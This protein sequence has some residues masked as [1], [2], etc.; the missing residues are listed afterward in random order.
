MPTS[1][2][3][4]VSSKS[5]ENCLFTSTATGIQPQLSMSHTYSYRTRRG[6]FRIVRQDNE[7]ELMFHNEELGTYDEPEDAAQELAAG[8][9][10]WP[11]FGDPS[12]LG[13]PDDLSFWDEE[14]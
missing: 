1:Q 4:T 3:L 9:S 8:Q 14:S 2:Q 7:W 5:F 10:A 12:S 6:T 13:I 11:S